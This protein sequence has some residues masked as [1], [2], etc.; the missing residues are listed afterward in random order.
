MLSHV[1]IA[2]ADFERALAF[3]APLMARLGLERSWY[4]GVKGQAC[5]RAPGHGRPLFFLSRPFEGEAVAGNG[6]MVAFLAQDRLVVR[7]VHGLAL[8]LGAR[9][10]GAP[11]LRLQYH[12]DYYGAY[13][14]DLDGNKICVVC[15]D[16]EGEVTVGA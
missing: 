7:E 4:D 8:S 2:I 14:R 12:P 5:F 3:Y 16:A 15:H 1:T 13:F 10:A 6:G 9:D 11:G